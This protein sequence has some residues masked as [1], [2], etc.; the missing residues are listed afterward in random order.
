MERE[1]GM[2]RGVGE[3]MQTEKKEAQLLTLEEFLL[4]SNENMRILR[5]DSW[6][7]FTAL[8]TNGRV[9]L[10]CVIDF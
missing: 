2:E 6:L 1:R 5:S 9:K 8:Q 3:E 7:A 10:C 4:L